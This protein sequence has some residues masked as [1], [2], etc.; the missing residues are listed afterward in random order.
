MGWAHSLVRA[1]WWAN[2]R[3]TW[4]RTEWRST[5]V[6]WALGLSQVAGGLCGPS[7]RWS[8]PPLITVTPQAKFPNALPAGSRM[9]AEKFLNRLPK[10]VIRQGQVIDIRGP[11]R[12]TLQV[13]PALIPQSSWGLFTT[14]PGPA[15]QSSVLPGGSDLWALGNG[16]DGGSLRAVQWSSGNCRAA[17]G[18]ALGPREQPDW[19][20]VG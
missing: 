14:N 17:E 11:I 18:S 16:Q 15:C 4:L 7:S 20:Q 12:D 10:V 1:M 3:C 9:T 13:R 2:Q 5:Q 8:L 19:L 6:S